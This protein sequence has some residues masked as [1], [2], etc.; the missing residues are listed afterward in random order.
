MIFM[1]VSSLGGRGFPMGVVAKGHLLLRKVVRRAWM[2][3][4]KPLFHRYGKN[5]RFDPYGMYTFATIAV[6]D[7]VNLGERPILWAAKSQIKIGNKV[8]FGP[9]VMV[10]AG[11]HNTS[12]VGQFMFDVVEKRPDDDVDVIIEDD[13]WI[14][15]RA[16]ILKGVVIGR[17]AVVG[18]GAV[19]TRSVPP[20]AVTA[21]APARVVKFRWDV[22]TILQ[23]EEKLYPPEKR[24]SRAALSASR[25]AIEVGMAAA[26]SAQA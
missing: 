14:G 24:I 6:G 17:G 11:N 20:Y 5:F 22:E 2:Y 4:Y 18:A 19:V 10:L 21:G 23:H 7:D 12:R 1:V 15:A 3:L 13:V 9:E 26:P 8:M 16:V 25:Q